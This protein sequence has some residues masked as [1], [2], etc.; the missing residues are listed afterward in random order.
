MR[1]NIEKL[2]ETIDA[3]ACRVLSPL[4]SKVVGALPDVVT[5]LPERKMSSALLAKRFPTK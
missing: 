1:I 2:E 3:Q 5:A 4:I